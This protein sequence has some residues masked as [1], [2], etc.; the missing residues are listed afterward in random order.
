MT[1]KGLCGTHSHF[2]MSFLPCA[3]NGVV[4]RKSAYETSQA[5]TYT[6]SFVLN[7]QKPTGNQRVV[8]GF[9]NGFN[10]FLNAF[11]R[12]AKTFNGL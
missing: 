9:S 7:E 10:G 6:N 3:A 4:R 5:K 1:I 8:N 12:C 11:N 2:H